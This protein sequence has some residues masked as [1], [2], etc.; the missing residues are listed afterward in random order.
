MVSFMLRPVLKSIRTFLGT[1]RLKGRQCFDHTKLLAGSDSSGPNHGLR[2][3]VND[4]SE[5]IS[6]MDSTYLDGQVQKIDV[7]M[8]TGHNIFIDDSHADRRGAV[9]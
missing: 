1:L 3:L 4:V 2:T 5:D 8:L 6:I 9:S 7:P